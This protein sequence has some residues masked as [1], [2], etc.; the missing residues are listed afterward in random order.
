MPVT[1]QAAEKFIS[2][3]AWVS[4]L[5]LAETIW[6]LDAASL[7]FRERRAPKAQELNNIVNVLRQR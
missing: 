3:G 1:R 5:V 6:V 7:F 2:G 4:R